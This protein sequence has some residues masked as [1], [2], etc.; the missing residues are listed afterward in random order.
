MLLNKQQ[1]ALTNELGTQP[2]TNNFAMNTAQHITQQ[3]KAQKI[4]PLFYHTDTAVCI[5]VIHALYNAGIRVIEFTNRGSAAPANFEAIVIERNN[6]MP[7]LVL[8]VGTIQS[9]DDAHLFINAG[10]DFIVSPVFDAGVC[11]V[12]YMNKIL[13]IPGCMTPTEIHVAKK[14]GC[15]LIKLFPGNVLGPEFVS[16]I[17]E[18]FPGIDFMPTGGVDITTE[19]ME[20]WLNAGVCAVG[21]GSKLITKTAL[22]NK[23][24]TKIETLTRQALQI[25]RS[26]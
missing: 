8:G 24:Y 2:A 4:L 9:S 3:I 23:D 22:E 11:D 6:S 10:A 17:R 16:S 13:W 12:A 18:L 14:A 19:N 25:A 15:R 1:K 5:A 7:D 26:L 21:L 20:A